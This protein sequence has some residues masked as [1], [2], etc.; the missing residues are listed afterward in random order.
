MSA[1][2]TSFT[3]KLPASSDFVPICGPAVTYMVRQ[4]ERL[5]PGRNS[6]DEP[7]EAWFC[8][9]PPTPKVPWKAYLC[10]CQSQ[11]LTLAI[12]IGMGVILD[13]FTTP[14]LFTDGFPG[15]A[16]LLTMANSCCRMVLKAIPAL[17]ENGVLQLT[18]T[19]APCALTS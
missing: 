1:G 8:R 19:N 7:P 13:S 9:F 14:N 17:N 2:T 5:T 16:E 12:T 3:L 4:N 15:P 10:R 18:V 6:A 11:S